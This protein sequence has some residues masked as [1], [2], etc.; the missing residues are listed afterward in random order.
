MIEPIEIVAYG[1]PQPKGSLTAFL[2]S[3]R[4]VMTE[5]KGKVAQKAYHDWRRTLKQA[6]VAARGE[7]PLLTGTLT[8][9]ITFRLHRG[10][11]VV[12][13]YPSITPDLDKLVRAVFDAMT[14]SVWKDDC[15]V[16][17]LNCRKLYAETEPPGATIT[18][19]QVLT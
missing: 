15:L 14:G 17:G 4:I 6:G 19:K 13:E 11:T 16:V 12:R 7:T 18:I 3:G 5:G 1:T 9:D 8:A 10:L 2:V